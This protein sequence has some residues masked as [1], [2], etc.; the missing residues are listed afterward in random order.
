M[1]SHTLL[2]FVQTSPP[3]SITYIDSGYVFVGSHCGDSQIILIEPSTSTS[4]ATA[5]TS[6]IMSSP[7]SNRSSPRKGKAKAR[8]SDSFDV[9]DVTELEHGKERAK[10]I[11]QFMNL[12]PVNDFCVIEEN[13]GGVVSA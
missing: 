11:E 2:T 12:A 3:T 8:S 6:A 13:G 7:E 4:G 9:P 10:I 1:N 5:S